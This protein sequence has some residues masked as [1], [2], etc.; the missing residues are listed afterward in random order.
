MAER[1][2]ISVRVDEDSFEAWSELRR[3]TRLDLSA[4]IAALGPRLLAQMKKD[5]GLGGLVDAAA[6]YQA[7]A[8]SRAPVKKKAARRRPSTPR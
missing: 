8:A 2:V 4:L 7:Q 6:D 5:P 1:R 3:R